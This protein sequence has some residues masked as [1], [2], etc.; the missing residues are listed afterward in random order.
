MQE[1]GEGEEQRIGDKIGQCGSRS[2]GYM[3]ECGIIGG[4]TLQTGA[5]DGSEGDGIPTGSR[6]GIHCIPG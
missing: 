3:R 2:E 4:D 1:Q 5:G 6:R